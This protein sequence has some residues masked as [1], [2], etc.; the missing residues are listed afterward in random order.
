M[1]SCPICDS[2]SITKFFDLPKQATTTSSGQFGGDGI[3]AWLCT[4]CGHA[5]KNTMPNAAEYYALE[6]QF[7]LES[8][9]DD[10]IYLINEDGSIT[11]RTQH[12]ARVFLDSIPL[13][14]GAHVLD[15]GCAK[16]LMAQ[17]I[18]AERPDISLW[19][20]DV[21]E[22]HRARWSEI[23]PLENS[24]VGTA[25][26]NW[27]G[28]FEAIALMFTLEHVEQPKEVLADVHRL[29][30]HGGFVHGVVPDVGHN[31]A[32]LIVRDHIHH[33]S[34]DS[35]KNLLRMSGFD[36]IAIDTHR[37]SAGLTFTARCHRPSCDQQV[38]KLLEISAQWTSRRD[39]I[40]QFEDEHRNVDSAIF[41]AGVNGAFVL[42]CL[43]NRTR[44]KV[45]I[46]NNPHLHGV[47]RF[48]CEIVS[49]KNLPMNV[50]VVYSALNPEAA[51]SI[52]SK[53]LGH[54]TDLKIC[55]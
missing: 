32:D 12:Q 42:S 5:F 44:V 30:K 34:I 38:K 19:L 43:E 31:V 3:R 21:T 14:S 24:V 6:Y 47:S 4:M 2:L 22:R 23:V 55:L 18:R 35:L 40:R 33:Y 50:Q 52:L 20:F 11:Y 46:D 28:T 17:W 25:P 16:G 41:G 26:E 37:Y 15:Y 51:L 8:D 48:G 13:D 10:Q 7:S 36:D 53:S 54:R 27:S 29:L 39:R 1:N 49:P 9:D 45:L